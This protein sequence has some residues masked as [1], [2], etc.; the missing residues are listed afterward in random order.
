MRALGAVLGSLADLGYDARWKGVRA[1]DAGAP[2]NRFRIFITAWPSDSNPYSNGFNSRGGYSRTV[3]K[4][5]PYRGLG[6]VT[7]ADRAAENNL[8]LLRTPVADETGGGAVSPAM[9]KAKGQTL[10][11]TGQ[12]IDLV[13]PGR[14][15]TPNTMD[16]LPPRDGEAMEKHLHRGNTGSRRSSSGNLRED[17]LNLPTPV[18]SEG[19]K[20]TNRQNAEQRAKTGQVFLT[21]VAQT[22][23]QGKT[24]WGQYEAAVRR[25]ETVLGREA[26]KPTEATGRDGQQQLSAKFTEWMM[27]LDEGWITSPEIGLTRNEALKACGNGVV[28]Q[29][30]VLALRGLLDGVAW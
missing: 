13:E 30:A 7:W 4:S 9:A 20:A 5:Q 17:I 22:I 3:T 1:A 10:R 26:P 29:Q 21:N 25:W 27:G 23:I 11:L 14:L 18:A 6:L 19:I 15:P 8:D 24:E 12:I 2:H 16:H 28:P